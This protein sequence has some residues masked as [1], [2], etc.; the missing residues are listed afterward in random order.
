MGQAPAT[1]FQVAVLVLFVLPGVVYQFLRERWRGPVPGEQVL[2]ERVLRA[3]SASVVLDAVY[4]LVAGPELL[5]LVR[6]TPGEPVRWDDP[7][8]RVR[9]VGFVA[10]MLF[11][12]VPAAAAGAVSVWQRRRLRARYRVTPTAWDH[13]FRDRGSCFVRLRMKDGTWVGGW[14][15]GQS[16]ATAYPQPRELFLESAWR[17]D[18]AGAFTGRV[19]HSA[20]LHVRADD[21]DLL[22]LLEPDR[23]ASRHTRG[24]GSHDRAVPGRIRTD[25]G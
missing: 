17:M 23:G 2:S 10:L 25:S 18:P 1:V 14:Y 11:A 16:Y 20:G 15:G 8:Q 4:M 19:A 24:G 22:E 3:L 5:R 9:L 21:A 7:G 13:M 6:G 12:A